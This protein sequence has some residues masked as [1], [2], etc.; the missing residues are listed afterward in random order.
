VS[1][2]RL[3]T[4]LPVYLAFVFG[5][6][7]DR[8]NPFGL[9]D[10]GLF[11][12]FGPISA[13]IFFW[14]AFAQITWI[15]LY[16]GV[17]FVVLSTRLIVAAYQG[18]ISLIGQEKLMAGRLATVWNAVLYVPVGFFAWLAGVATVSLKPYQTFSILGAMALVIGA[19]G[20]WK[21]KEVFTGAYDSPEAKTLDLWGDVRRLLKHKAI[22][23]PVLIMFLWNFAPGSQTP[24]QYYLTNTLHASDS[25]YANF[26]AVFTIAF[27]PTFFLYGYLCTRYPLKKLLFWGTVVAVPQMVPLLFVH[28]AMGA[29]LLA[30]PIGL[31]GGVATAAYYDLAM[32]SCPPGLQGTLMLMVDGVY[33]LCQRA[34]DL[35]GSKIY[36]SDH[37]NGFL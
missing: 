18:L 24:L 23:A 9:R 32:R 26:N 12:I 15:G 29:V 11:L 33:Y 28:S 7:R 2:F 19:L 8:W 13:A 34:G 31:M 14:L 27:L 30:I 4:A 21:P 22:Y 35:L 25:A 20:F 16:T 36:D 17:I 3:W 6:V 1:T 5:L 37:K 10:R